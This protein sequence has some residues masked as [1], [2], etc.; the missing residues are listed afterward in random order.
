ME[1]ELLKLLIRQQAISTCAIIEALKANGRKTLT[2]KTA[3]LIMEEYELLPK[4]VE[5]AIKHAEDLGKKPVAK[6]QKRI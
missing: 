1:A 6:V 4:Q 2:E 5:K 3:S